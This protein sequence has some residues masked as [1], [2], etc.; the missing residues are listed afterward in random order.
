MLSTVQTRQELSEY[1]KSKYISVGQC[2]GRTILKCTVSFDL[3]V[4]H[5]A[6]GYFT[7]IS[8]G[9]IGICTGLPFYLETDMSL[10]K[11]HEIIDDSVIKRVFDGEKRFKQEQDYN[12]A[13]ADVK[14][15]AK[16]LGKNV[17]IHE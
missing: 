10:L 6:G 8:V 16:I 4:Y 12:V 14:R 13:V 1:L 9:E 7:C 3:V 2:V 17:T 15:L 5:F 11:K